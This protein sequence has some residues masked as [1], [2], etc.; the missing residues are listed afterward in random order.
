[1]V[2]HGNPGE[3]AKVRGTMTSL[4][5]VFLCCTALGACGASLVLGRHPAWFA[6][7]FVAVVVATALFWRKG[8]RRVES[9]FKGARGEER[10]AGILE[11]LPDAWHVFH[12]FAVGRYH[13]DHVL[14]G[15]TGVRSVAHHV[16][17]ADEHLGPLL[18]RVRQRARAPADSHGCPT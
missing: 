5:P 7:G 4:W 16:P 10:V 14:V 12:D 3:W 9:Y 1:M 6:A 18:P 13:V 11:S 8:L 2:R 17:E 15:P